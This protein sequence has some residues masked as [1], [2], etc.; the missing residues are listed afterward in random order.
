[1]K[2]NDINIKECTIYKWILYLLNNPNYISYSYKT[3]LHNLLVF[4]NLIYYKK[5]SKDALSINIKISNKGFFIDNLDSVLIKM[6]KAELVGVRY[7]IYGA[8]IIPLTSLD[9]EAYTEEELF[10]LDIINN[11]INRLSDSLLENY[12][13]G[14]VAWSKDKINSVIN[15]SDINIGEFIEFIKKTEEHPILNRR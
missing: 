10:I 5:Y 14:N 4:S 11:S 7:G 2:Y 1:M 13:I 15:L 6:E 9:K 12:A 8:H 3:R